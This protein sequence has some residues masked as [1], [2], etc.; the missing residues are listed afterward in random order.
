MRKLQ[1]GALRWGRVD[2]P[3]IPRVSRTLHGGKL[4][5]VT[6]RTLKSLQGLRDSTAHMVTWT[7]RT[8]VALVGTGTMELLQN[9]H[10]ESGEKPCP[11][12]ELSQVIHSSCSP[13]PPSGRP[14][15]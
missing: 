13:P 12:Q 3:W 10:P 9:S 4:W 8:Q 7:M 11:P 1:G 2:T 5:A 15:L 14:D 6:S